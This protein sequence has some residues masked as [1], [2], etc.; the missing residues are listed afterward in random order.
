MPTPEEYVA[1]AMR[2]QAQVRKAQREVA[3]EIAA[4]RAEEE[5]K[6]GGTIPQGEP[7]LEERS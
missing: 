1:E 7:E 2:R 5:A 6:R 4:A 3:A